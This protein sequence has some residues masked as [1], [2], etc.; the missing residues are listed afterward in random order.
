MV[1]SIRIYRPS[2]GN[3]PAFIVDPAS[4]DS[5]TRDEVPMHGSGAGDHFEDDSTYDDGLGLNGRMDA[6]KPRKMSPREERMKWWR[7]YAMHFLFSWNSRTFEYVSIFLV[8]LAFPK[9]LF[10]TSI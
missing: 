2:G 7:I 3:E 8:A 5:V 4:V 10:A 9:G 1:L 6:P